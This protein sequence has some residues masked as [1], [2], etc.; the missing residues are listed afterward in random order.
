MTH[1]AGSVLA[2]ETTADAFLGLLAARGIARGDVVGVLRQR[3]RI[4]LA[5][6]A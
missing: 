6:G 1:A 3:W 4:G 5:P 2:S